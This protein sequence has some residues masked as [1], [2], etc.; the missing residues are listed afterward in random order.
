MHAYIH[1]YIH[2]NTHTQ[3]SLNYTTVIANFIAYR[4]LSELFL[5]VEV[6]R[7]IET[8]SDLFCNLAKLRLPRKWLTLPKNTVRKENT[9]RCTI[10]LFS[11]RNM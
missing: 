6:W 4:K 11:N 1:T 5:D 2:T 7:R 3:S 8:G 9:L 10:R